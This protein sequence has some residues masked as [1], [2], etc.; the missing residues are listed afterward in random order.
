METSTPL[1]RMGDFKE[2][3]FWRDGK[4]VVSKMIHTSKID[5]RWY[6]YPLITRQGKILE[7]DTAFNYWQMSD[8]KVF[9]VFI[10]EEEAKEAA[11]DQSRKAGQL[12]QEVFPHSQLNYK[13][14]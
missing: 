9:E 8:P 7:P 4:S 14:A 11:Q 10:T 6:N 5:D 2:E 13:D 3:T 1:E 12:F